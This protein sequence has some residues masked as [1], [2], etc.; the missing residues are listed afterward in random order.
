MN[1]YVVGVRPLYF[2]IV[3]E[4]G[5]LKTFPE[6]KVFTH[7]PVWF[8]RYTIHCFPALAKYCNYVTS[9]LM[10]FWYNQSTYRPIVFLCDS[11]ITYCVWVLLYSYYFIVCWSRHYMQS[12]QSGTWNNSPITVRYPSDMYGRVLLFWWLDVWWRSAMLGVT[13]T[14]VCFYSDDLTSDDALLCWEWPVRSVVWF[15]LMT[16]R[17]MTLCYAGSDLYGRVLLFWWLDV[18]WRSA[19]LGVTCTVGDVCVCFYSDDLTSD[20]A[21]LCWEWPVRSVVC[22]YSDDLTSDD[23]LLCW[24]WPVRSCAFILMT[25][26]L[27]TL[28]CWEWHVRVWFWWLDVWWRSAM[29]GVTV[30]SCAFILMTWRLMT[31]CYA[32]SWPVRSV[33]CFYSDDLTSDDALLCWEW[34][35]RSVVCFLFWWLDVWWRSAMLG[36]TCTVGR[37]LSFWW[38]DVWWRSA[39]LMEWP[40]RSVV[41][42]HSDDL[43]SDDALLCWEWHVRSCAFILMTW[44]LMTLC[45]AGSDLYGRSCAF[46]LMTW[47]L[48]TLCYAGS[49]LYGRLCAFILMT[50]R[51]MTL[52]YAGSDLYGRLCAFILMTWRLMTL[53]YAGSYMYGRVLS[54]WWLDVW[55]RSAMLGVTCTVVC[56]HS[57][58]LTSD[59][60]LLCWEWH[61]RSVVCFYSDDLT[62]DDAL[63]CWEWHVRSCAF[64]LMT[65]RLMTL[66]YAGSDMYVCFYSVGCVLSFWWLDVWWRSAMLGV[67][68][69]VVCFHSDDLTSDDALLCWEWPVRSVVCFHS[70]D[71][72]SDDALLCWEWHVRS[73]VCFYSDD[74][75]SDDAL[76]CWEWPVRSCAFILMTWRLMTL[77]YAGSDLYG[78]VFYSDDLT[79]D[80]A[81]L[82]WDWPVRSVVCF[83]SDDLTS[84]DAL[85]CWEWP[86]RSVVC[87]H[88]DDLTSDDALLCWE[89]PVRSCAFILMTWRLMT[90][91]YAGSDMYGRV[92]SFWWLDVWWRSAMLGVTCTV[93]RVLLFWWLDVWWRSAMLG[94][95]CTVVCFYSDD[96]TSDDA[97]L[98]W[99]WHVRSVVC[100]HSDDLTSDDALLC[101]EWPVR[102]VVC[103]HSD[104]LTSDDALLC[105]EWH[106]RS[107]V[108]FHSDDLTSDDAL[109]CWELHVRSCAFILMTWR[110]MTLCYA[111]SDMYGRVLS[112][113]WLDVW[114]RSAMLG[115]TCTVGCVLSFWWLDVWW[116]SAM[117]GVT[118][119]LGSVVCFHSDD[120]TSDD[121][122]LCWALHVRSCA[123]ILMTWRLMTLC[124]AGSDLYGRL[125]AFIL[126]TWR[127]MTLCYAGRYMYGRVLLFWWLDVWWRS[128]MLGVTCTVVCFYSDDLTSDDALLRWEWPVRSV[129]CFHSDD[130][131]SDDAL[132]CLEW[133]VRS[134]AFILMTWRLMTLCY[135]GSDLYGRVL[136]FWWLDVWWRSAMLGVTCTV[137]RVLSFWWLD[138]WWRSAMLGVTC[139]V[140]CFILM[141]WRL[142]TLCYAGSDLYGR[143]LLFWW[144]DVW[145]RSAMLGVTC[146]VV[147][148]YS[149]DLTSD[150]AL[151]CWEWHVRSCAFILMTWRL[152]TLCYAGSDMYG[153]VLSFWWLDVWWRSA[154]LGVTCTV[155]RVLLFWWLDVWW[156]SAML[157]VTC[158]VVCFY[159]DDLTSDDALLCWEWPVRSCVLSFWWLDVWWRSAMLGVTCTVGRVLS[160]WWLDVWWRSAMLGVTCTVVC[161]YISKWWSHLQR[162]Y[163][164]IRGRNIVIGV[165]SKCRVIASET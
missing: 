156:R 83:H 8:Y 64:I 120:L 160:F 7:P 86:V 60:A 51:L 30:R 129:V 52:C 92:L 9:G 138:V 133:P 58:D 53:C 43:T 13:C 127:L 85:L 165:I 81:L 76:L 75:T 99:E 70:D 3:S 134:C 23:A 1:T 16:W 49:D 143:V 12:T 89:W 94:L 37:V 48:M 135:A 110:L 148:F 67:T 38:L 40:V 6:L 56:F 149:D 161:F 11:P 139:T 102:S 164:K 44:R 36:V 142:M 69:T 93:G 59:D 21:L 147:C 54:F 14:V 72:T 112:F 74:L 10:C 88:S 158:T 98:C 146:T 73:V 5:S 32:G 80:D 63:L 155:G 118:C 109:L 31:L 125:C 116:R 163:V 124:Y 131:T 71:L 101:W 108:C 128:A 103:F 27:M 123:F 78:R 137:G 62:S 151:L 97:L 144:L 84:D 95:T 91:C 2:F 141:T 28:L 113:W 82:C 104:D 26:R 42:F 150:D 115:V 114:W 55:W 162:G 29:L 50:W 68:C 121:A 136:S 4:R 117:L 87:F 20:D 57:D 159:S 34:H 35:V 19:M 111:G 140:V 77:C 46:I 65:W 18:W 25:W 66:C 107:V 154:M 61:V 100:F 79:S 39:M 105:W 119:M 15:I 157:G 122:L 106:V 45:Y 96:L 130:L 17:L 22:F 145:W 41:C 126:M 152:M 153:R 132:L 47:R 33:V 90:L 24:E